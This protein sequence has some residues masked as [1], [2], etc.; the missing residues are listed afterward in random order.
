[1]KL[2]RDR[3][4]PSARSGPRRKQPL[5]PA[6]CVFALCGLRL[7]KP[8]SLIRDADLNL[9][10]AGLPALPDVGSSETE[11][12]RPTCPFVQVIIEPARLTRDAPPVFSGGV[13][14]C[15]AEVTQGFSPGGEAH[16]ERRLL[17]R[18][19]APGGSPGIASPSGGGAERSEAEG[20]RDDGEPLSALRAASPLGGSSGSAAARRAIVVEWGFGSGDTV[21]RVLPGFLHEEKAPSPGQ[22]KTPG[23]S[24]GGLE[25][26]CAGIRRCPGPSW[27]RQPSG[28]RQRW[29][30]P[31]GRPACR[32]R[33][34]RHS[35]P[36]RC[37]S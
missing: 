7:I 11:L 23:L 13:F 32:T 29:R 18:Q 36:C 30:R 15:P 28:S 1:M 9:R 16:G 31:S 35:R 4:S 14:V 5:I 33:R 19:K 21:L 2:G 24:T 22:R 3:P 26:T 25:F 27:P 12:R 17:L 10:I 8:T 20:V 37:S 34:R 6:E